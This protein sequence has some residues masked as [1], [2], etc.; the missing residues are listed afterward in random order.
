[1]NYDDLEISQKWENNSKLAV[2]NEKMQQDSEKSWKILTGI[3]IEVNT[4]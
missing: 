1:M 2:K 4:F 3:M